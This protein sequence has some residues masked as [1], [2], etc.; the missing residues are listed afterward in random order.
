LAVGIAL[1]V[2]LVALAVLPPLLFA[3]RLPDPLATHWAG[4]SGR[5]DGALPLA[6]YAVLN[7]IFAGIPAAIV[8]HLARKPAPAEVAPAV[9]I[10]TFVAALSAALSCAVVG[11]NLDA[12]TWREAALGPLPVL[13]ALAAALALAVVGGRAARRLE[14]RAAAPELA[15]SAGLRAGERAMW[16]GRARGRWALPLA[17]VLVAS[18]VAL[19][20]LAN[21]WIGALAVLLGAVALPFTSLRVRADRHGVELRYGPFGWPRSRIALAEIRSAGALELA[22]LQWGGWGY[23]GSRRLFRKAAV[24]LRAGPA[25]RLELADDTLL[26]VTV[27]DAEAGAGL[28]NDLLARGPAAPGRA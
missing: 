4:A 14:S 8:W 10:A 1:P 19:G 20:L 23:R 5:P 7:L 17:A 6:L 13:V 12:P 15:P 22:P 25:L 27:D 21:I 11:A 28:L 16:I 2:G 26:V 24:V 9:G 3:S 18:G